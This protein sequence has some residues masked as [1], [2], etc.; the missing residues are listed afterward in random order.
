MAVREA[1]RG[2]GGVHTEYMIG[3]QVGKVRGKRG[4]T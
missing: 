1:N 4:H 2:G 3:G